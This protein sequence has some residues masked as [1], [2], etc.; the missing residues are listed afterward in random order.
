MLQVWNVSASGTR[1]I[2]LN[3]DTFLLKIFDATLGD[4]CRTSWDLEFIMNENSRFRPFYSYLRMQ[5]TK[6]IRAY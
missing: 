1:F 4:L 2:G 5:R 6:Q 3:R